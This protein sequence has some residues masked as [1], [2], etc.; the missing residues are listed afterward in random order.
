MEGGVGGAEVYRKFPPQAPFIAGPLTHVEKVDQKA[1]GQP[2][3]ERNERF[4]HSLTDG[5]RRSSHFICDQ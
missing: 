3:G 1:N 5:P 2:S 4:V